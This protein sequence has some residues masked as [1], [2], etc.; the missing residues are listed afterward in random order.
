MDVIINHELKN[1][2]HTISIIGQHETIVRND[3]RLITQI[4]K[5]LDERWNILESI[6]DGNKEKN[7]HLLSSYTDFVFVEVG[8]LLFR[9]NITRD[10]NSKNNYKN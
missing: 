9:V 2:S 4:I 6:N 5:R 7:A 3:A 10:G 8:V 1:R